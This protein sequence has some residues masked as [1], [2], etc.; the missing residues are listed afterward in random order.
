VA[1][2]VSRTTP[3]FA[4]FAIVSGD[5]GLGNLMRFPLGTH[6]GIVVAR[7]PNNWPV[8]A[9]N[10]AIMAGL[11]GLTDEEIAGNLVVIEPG[12]VRVRR[13]R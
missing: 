9:L 12:R 1:F 6:H 3:S 10:A 13:Q 4:S 5:L 8:G 2:E 7:F 11:R